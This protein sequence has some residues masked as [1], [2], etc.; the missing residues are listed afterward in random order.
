MIRF[1]IAQ[2]SQPLL[3]ARYVISGLIA[4]SVQVGS[5]A[6]FVEKMGFHH[7]TAVPIAFIISAVVAFCFQ[8]F[9][10]FRDSS[11]E[12]THFQAA[13]YIALVFIALALNMALM[14][15]LVDI[16][17]LWYIFAQV[18]TIG[19]VTIVT[20]LCNKNIVFR[21]GFIIPHATGAGISKE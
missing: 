3:V 9:W 4:A 8:K 5:L 2:L 17:L 13:L 7:T 19:L 14:Y 18:V 10:T 11:M 15:I 12:H 21:R 6:F 20:F 1:L 16:F